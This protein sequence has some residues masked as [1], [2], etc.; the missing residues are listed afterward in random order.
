LRT[1]ECHWSG[2]LPRLLAVHGTF[3][4]EGF[5]AHWADAPVPLTDAVIAVP[6]QP[7]L[8]VRTE[9]P[10]LVSRPGDV[11]APGRYVSGRWLSDE[12]TRRQAL[13]KT[14]LHP[15]TG[16]TR[17][18]SQPLLFGW[19][20]PVEMGFQFPRHDERVGTALWSI[21]VHVDKSPAGTPVVI[22]SPFVPFRAAAR[23]DG[24]AASPLY[25]Y[26]TGLWVASQKPS[27]TWL[28]FEV[29]KAVLPFALDRARLTLQITAPSRTVKI[30]RSAA[31]GKQPLRQLNN[32]IG[33]IEITLQGETLPS[34]DSEGRLVLGITVSPEADAADARLGKPWKIDLVQLEIAGV[35]RDDAQK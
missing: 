22:P 18:I 12:Q 19:G 6:G 21:P 14:L 25:D 30:L 8:S 10:R 26:R 17:E 29:P 27:E 28:R 33:R 32:P 34:L 5:V 35:A 2:D 31:G 3:T 11:L 9:G 15:E 16:P 4:A 23:P 20:D 1:A 24:E 7:Y 13:L